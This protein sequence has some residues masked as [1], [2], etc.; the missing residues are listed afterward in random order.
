[1]SDL[2]LGRHFG[3]LTK[4]YF[5]A[6]TRRLSKLDI[7]R[8]FSPLIVVAETP[9]CTQQHL[10]D[11]MKMDKASMVRVV[12]Y[13]SDNKYLV[14]VKNA[15]DRREVFLELTEKGKKKLPQIYKAINDLNQTAI[16]GLNKKESE[17][18][19]RCLCLVSKN[20]GSEPADE[21]ILNL[22]KSKRKK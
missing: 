15:K 2:P 11:V 9:C 18:F 22:K 7:E 12:D 3:R 16:K 8:H 1:M 5:G 20:L 21:I 17:E 4:L 6:L 19:F 14:R 13:L 10:C